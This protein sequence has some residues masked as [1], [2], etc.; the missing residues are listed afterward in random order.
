MSDSWCECALTVPTATLRAALPS[1]E[2]TLSLSASHPPLCRLWP[3]RVCFPPPSVTLSWTFRV[4]VTGSCHCECGFQGSACWARGRTLF[5][6]TAEPRLTAWVGRGVFPFLSRHAGAVCVC[7][8]FGAM[9]LHTCCARACLSARLRSGVYPDQIAGPRDNSGLSGLRNCQAVLQSGHAVAFPP[10]VSVDL[11]FPW[12]LQPSRRLWGGSSRWLCFASPCGQGSEH[13][14]SGTSLA[15]GMFGEMSVQSFC[16]FLHWGFV[17]YYR[18][19]SH[20]GVLNTDPLPDMRFTN[21][22]S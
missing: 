10:A 13:R 16:P 12:K 11:G 7:G 5:L 8:Y 20:L 1:Q 14:F 19:N 18:Y 17:F 15:T 22:F 6:P 2:E 3:P 9:L 21:I 4:P